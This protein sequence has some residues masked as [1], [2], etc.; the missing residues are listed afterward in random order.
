MP[1]R[2]LGE[3][4]HF[5]PWTER[6]QEETAQLIAS[7]YRGHIDSQI[8]DQYRSTAGARRF[9]FNIVQYP[10]CGTFFQPASWV[11]FQRETGR[12]C[13]ASLA[14][15]VAGDVGHITQICVAPWMQGWG[16]G[17]EL[18]RR[19][20]ESLEEARARKVSL[21]VTAANQGAVRLYERV[22]FQLVR[23]FPAL[24]WEGF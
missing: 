4:V 23:Q 20:L 16:V 15:L 18:L 10:G 21:T 14:S 13:G 11:A 22:G 8:N 5:K 19:S 17:Y 3:L 24:V 1:P 7:A 9:L 12:V 2:Q 6:Y